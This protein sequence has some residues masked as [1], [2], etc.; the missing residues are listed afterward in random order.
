[1]IQGPP[2]AVYLRSTVV[3]GERPDESRD[4][5]RSRRGVADDRTS[6]GQGWWRAGSA[7]ASGLTCLFSVSSVAKSS[8][9]RSLSLNSG[10]VR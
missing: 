1:M 8:A 2:V 3:H 7:N 6:Q 4:V 9:A 5:L 10:L